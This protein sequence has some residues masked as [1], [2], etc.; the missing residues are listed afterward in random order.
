MDQLSCMQRRSSIKWNLVKIQSAC[1]RFILPIKKSNFIWISRLPLKLN[2]KKT[3]NCGKRFHSM[4]M[5]S[6][7]Y[8]VCIVILAIAS[9][10]AHQAHCVCVWYVNDIHIPL[11][12][13]ACKQK[14]WRIQSNIIH[15]RVYLPNLTTRSKR[16]GFL[17][18]HGFRYI[19]FWFRS[20]YLFNLANIDVMSNCSGNACA[21]CVE[22]KK[23]AQFWNKNP[24]AC[25]TIQIQ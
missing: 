10:C 2:A 7:A 3:W 6:N 5:V 20:I 21:W 25:R 8:C 1:I 13:S 9:I 22:Q 19:W 14:W 24:H 16:H 11:K 23:S 4:L 12:S 17:F 18:I 15:S